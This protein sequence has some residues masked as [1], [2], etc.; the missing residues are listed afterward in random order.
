[1]L[2]ETVDTELWHAQRC[3]R[4]PRRPRWICLAAT[5]LARVD[6][7]AGDDAAPAPSRCSS[8]G[9]SRVCALLHPTGRPTGERSAAGPGA[10]G[11][12]GRACRPRGG[13]SRGR[14]RP[15][16]T[17]SSPSRWLELRRSNYSHQLLSCAS[18]RREDRRNHRRRPRSQADY[19]VAK[20]ATSGAPTAAHAGTAGPAHRN[21]HAH[22]G[23][24]CCGR[25]SAAGRRRAA[26]ARAEAEARDAA[27]TEQPSIDGRPPFAPSRPAHPRP[28]CRLRGADRLAPAGQDR[29]H[30]GDRD[31]VCAGA[32]AVALTASR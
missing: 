16:A 24:R 31:R 18:R 17:P 13:G 27:L 11:R 23:R 32:A 26:T 15:V 2:A 28:A 5:R 21:R 29:R 14:R 10:G 12:R 3:C 22:C 20:V 19:W 9:S 6:L 30:E 25:Q 7:A 1:M 8:S 4:P